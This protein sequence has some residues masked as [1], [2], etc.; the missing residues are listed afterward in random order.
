MRNLL[1]GSDNGQKK[2]DLSFHSHHYAA[3]A[4]IETTAMISMGLLLLA[5]ITLSPTG[6]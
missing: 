5:T 2:P 6:S 3:I 4:P 1:R